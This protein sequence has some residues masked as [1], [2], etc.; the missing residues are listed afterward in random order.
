MRFTLLAIVALALAGTAQA[1]PPLIYLNYQ[2]YLAGA[3]DTLP[4][5]E[6]VNMA[7]RIYDVAVGASPLWQEVHAAVPVTKGFYNI[8]LGQSE[9]L[10]PDLFELEQLFLEVTVNGETLSPRKLITH[11]ARSVW[12]YQ[13]A[14][15][16]SATNA[17][18]ATNNATNAT[19]AGHATRADSA[20]YA[21]AAGSAPLAAHNHIGEYWT[22]TGNG[23]AMKISATTASALYGFVDTIY[24]GGTGSVYGA[25]H[26][27]YGNNTG[28]RCGVKTVADNGN[29][30]GAAYGGSFETNGSSTGTGERRGVN[31]YAYLSSGAG[32]VYGAYSYGYASNSYSNYVYGGNVIADGGSG[33]ATKYGL[34][35]NATGA[36]FNYGVY[37]TASGGGTN[38]AGYF[39]GN[40]ATTGKFSFASTYLPA[41]AG[42]PSGSVGDIAY[43]NNYIYIKTA[44]GWKRA[45]LSGGW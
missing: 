39:A 1:A 19:N 43:D 5:N 32:P 15:A 12:S 38:Y 6:A 8:V 18:N 25:V 40:L 34:Y 26:Y 42:D 33:S 17:T 23:L 30:G 13:A 27:V 41:A 22:G 36:G 44:S 24:N 35:A 45:V 10:D 21:T 7:V 9:L 4:L 31:S 2:G 11:A 37:A 16:A 29:T 20:T 3:A 28:L 14:L